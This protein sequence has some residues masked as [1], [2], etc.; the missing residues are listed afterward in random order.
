MR[1]GA[2]SARSLWWA[3]RVG[4]CLRVAP[5]I[6]SRVSLARPPGPQCVGAVISQCRS[7]SAAC[8]GSRTPSSERPQ[9]VEAPRSGGHGG[10][11]GVLVWP[12]GFCSCLCP[13][14]W[15]A[16]GLSGG[17]SPRCSLKRDALGPLSAS[18]RSVLNKGNA[19]GLRGPLRGASTRPPPAPLAPDSQLRAWSR[20]LPKR[21]PQPIRRVFT[22]MATQ[23]GLVGVYISWTGTRCAL[24]GL[25]STLS[26]GLLLNARRH[27]HRGV[28]HR[29]RAW[30]QGPRAKLA[31]RSLRGTRHQRAPCAAT[32]NATA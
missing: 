32:E 28:R 9:G 18:L 19:K 14:R 26:R 5:V 21:T 2:V 22:A 24:A 25:L 6:P 29:A 16:T 30:V 27:R 3:T 10:V 23:M 8:F 7:T 31:S 11:R 13:G 15:P 1:D 20:N 17:V 12:M 4:F